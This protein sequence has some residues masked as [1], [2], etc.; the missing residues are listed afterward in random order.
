MRP[1]GGLLVVVAL[2]ATLTSCGRHAAIRQDPVLPPPVARSAPTQPEP[3]CADGLRFTTEGGDAASGL[4][5][6]SVEVVNCGTE[7]VQLN[8]HPQVRL[9]DERWQPLDVS[10]LPGSGGIAQVGGF[11]DPPQPITVRPGERARSAFLWR[12]THTT[13]GPPQVGSHVDIAAAPGG[14]WQSLVPVSPARDINID[15]GNTG[16]VGVRAWYR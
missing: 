7:P 1:G 3:A 6:M 11:D 16:R 8:G 5:V 15:L 2:L 10:V 14:A 13:T 9:L 4:R 12:N